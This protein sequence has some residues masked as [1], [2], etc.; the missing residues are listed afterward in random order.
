LKDNKTPISLIVVAILLFI[1]RGSIPFFK[2]P[3]IILYIVLIA[4]SIKQILASSKKIFTLEFFKQY[5]VVLVSFVLFV[6]SFFITKKLYLVTVKDL[7]NMLFLFSFYIM[8]SIYIDRKE[9]LTFFMNI[10]VG[11]IVIFAFII[12]FD[13]LGNV[14][15]IF[16]S[17]NF[18]LQLDYNFEILPILFG[19]VGLLSFI[20]K[21][22]SKVAEYLYG[23]LLFIFTISVI[24]SGSRRGMIVLFIILALLIIFQ[25]FFAGKR[26]NVVRKQRIS[27]VFFCLAMLLFASFSYLFI[28]HTSGSFKNRTLLALGTKNLYAAKDR[29]TTSA[30]RYS[31]VFNKNVSFE[32]VDKLLWSPVFD[33]NDPDSGWG[34]R[35]HVTTFPLSGDNVEI[36]PAGARG[37]LLDQASGAIEWGGNSYT[38]TQLCTTQIKGS[39]DLEASVYCYVSKDFNGDWT[40]MIISPDN[41]TWL[42]SATYDTDKKGS[43]QKLS[44]TTTCQEKEVSMF[45][46]FCKNGV[47][48]FKTLNGYVVF[49]YPQLKIVAKKDRS[50][51]EISGNQYSVSIESN[52]YCMPQLKKRTFAFPANTQDASFDFSN[53]H[54]TKYL[55]RVKETDPLRSLISRLVLE[56]TTYFKYKANIEVDTVSNPF[57]DQ[58]TGRWQFALQIFTKE[59]NLAQKIFGGGFNFLNWYG[60]YFLKDKTKSDWPHNPFLAILL[61][62]GILGLLF[63]CLLIYRAFFY[64]LKYIK[65]YQILFVLFLISFFFTFFSGSSSFDPPIMGFFI[66]LPFFIQSI[67]KNEMEATLFK[68]T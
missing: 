14:L 24:I 58:R 1:Y 40:R 51:S 25:V 9:E 44:V 68:K 18:S 42:A 19:M 49:A 46:Y 4:F 43:W 3:F 41:L 29:I 64:Y 28:F 39:E 54:L 33:P 53:L 35:K 21:A 36:V 7:V 66:I 6:F 16:S 11:L 63:Y 65:K 26:V 31:T 38:F 8:M 34:Y 45:L 47:S 55:L 50:H 17:K 23:L 32:D 52:N 57:L 5:S 12:S 48:D 20:I 37:Y 67:H 61:Y 2:Y 62:S 60:Y 22:R 27:L 56:D 59:Y 15:Y 30:V 13:V 10:L